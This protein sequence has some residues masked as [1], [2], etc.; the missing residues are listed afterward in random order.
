MITLVRYELLKLQRRSLLVLTII[1]LV[2]NAAVCVYSVNKNS[3]MPIDSLDEMMRLYNSDPETMT[4]EYEFLL[5]WKAGQNRIALEQMKLGNIGYTPEKLQNRYAPDG[6]DDLDLFD[7]LFR[8]I[9]RISN[10]SGSIDDV[11]EDA[12]NNIAAFRKMGIP[13]DSYNTK[14]Q[15]YLISRYEN[16]KAEA[17]LIPEVVRGWNEFFSCNYVNIIISLIL[18]VVSSV[19]IINEKNVGILPIMK[20]SRRGRRMVALAKI[21]TL[22][23]ISCFVLLLFTA[24]SY[25]IVGLICGFS[26]RDQAV[27][28]LDEFMYCPLVITTGQFFWLTVAA[29]L[30]AFALFSSIILL[31]GTIFYKY[32]VVYTVGIAVYG[33][34]LVLYRIDFLDPDNPLRIMNLVSVTDPEMIFSR[35]RAI[36]LF[37]KVVDYLVSLPVVYLTIYLICS[38]CF[39]VIF[40]GHDKSAAIGRRSSRIRIQRPLWG[41]AESITRNGGSRDHSMSIFI[42]EVFKQLIAY[43]YLWLILLMLA[44]KVGTAYYRYNDT[45]TYKDNVYKEYMIILSGEYTAEKRQYIT[46]ERSYI[47]RTIDSLTEKQY[48]YLNGDIT[49]EAYEKFIAE[50]NYAYSR[51]ELFARI[52]GHAAYIDRLAAEGKKAE[53]LYDTGWRELFFT[54]FDITLYIALIL[55]FSDIFASEYLNGASGGGFA[56]IMRTAKNGRR[57][58]FFCKYVYAALTGIVLCAIWNLVDF[59]MISGAYELSGVSQPLI[60]IEAFEGLD[61]MTVLQYS[62]CLYSVRILAALILSCFISG[63]SV[64]LRR[65]ISVMTMTVVLTLFPALLVYYGFETFRRIDFTGFFRGTPM[66]LQGSAGVLYMFVCLIVCAVTSACA[67]RRWND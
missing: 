21:V 4:A 43:R 22:L 59:V 50:Y 14:Y 62:I 64:L 29:K 61:G 18:L 44:L 6:F 27:Q 56:Q 26:S 51:N 28:M 65:N 19:T 23:M 41:L 58:I 63:A 10:F 25:I 66:I 1:C 32:G 8:L 7:E 38:A 33:M 13:E 34:S 24:E 42:M 39:V 20:V 52:E 49:L 47:D 17:K 11:I 12:D 67:L 31:C 57:K 35:L 46:D 36:N 53:F 54:D 5:D 55:L 30:L 48:E 3:G 2:L 9:N 15:Y 45:G 60:S 37:G 40:K 16:V